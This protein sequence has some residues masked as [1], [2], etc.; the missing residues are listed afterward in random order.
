MAFYGLWRLYQSLNNHD[1][2][3]IQ[4]YKHCLNINSESLKANLQLGI[5]YLKTKNYEEK[6]KMFTNSNKIRTK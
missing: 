6:F 3:A 5:I 2:E 4:C 1:N